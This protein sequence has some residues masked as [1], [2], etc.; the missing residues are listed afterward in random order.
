MHRSEFIGVTKWPLEFVGWGSFFVPGRGRCRFCG[1]LGQVWPN[2]RPKTREQGTTRLF[3]LQ[4]AQPVHS[5]PEG[6][7]A[8][9]K[10]HK[11]PLFLG[12]VAPQRCP[13]R[14]WGV[15]F[16]GSTMLGKLHDAPTAQQG[17]NRDAQAKAKCRKVDASSYCSTL[18]LLMASWR[19][20]TRSVQVLSRIEASA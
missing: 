5:M 17:E 11:S 1:G 12:M 20:T 7:V 10:G 4:S 14:L 8:Y 2:N 9:A 15:L 16:G 13:D 6:P 3:V 19:N 18:S